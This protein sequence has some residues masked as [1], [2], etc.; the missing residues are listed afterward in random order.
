MRGEISQGPHN[1]RANGKGVTHVGVD[2]GPQ[3]RVQHND[4]AKRG[5][6]E[7]GRR[8]RD[9]GRSQR[10]LCSGHRPPDSCR[11]FSFVTPL[12]LEWKTH[13]FGVGGGIIFEH[14]DA[15]VFLL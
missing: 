7:S 2:S 12:Q 1:L 14:N 8:G 15:T 4:R 5:A 13:F 6:C 9:L 10:C 3:R 11:L